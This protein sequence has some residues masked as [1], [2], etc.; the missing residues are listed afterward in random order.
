MSSET[1]QRKEFIYNLGAIQL[2]FTLRTDVK[3][4]LK[5][6]KELIERAVRDIDTELTNFDK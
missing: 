3:A 5:A 4:E 2:K 1:I 6:F